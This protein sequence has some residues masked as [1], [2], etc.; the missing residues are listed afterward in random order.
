[1]SDEYIPE[2]DLGIDD[3][4]EFDEQLEDDGDLE[5]IT[6][7]EVDRVVNALEE[8]I[9]SVESENIR[10]CLEEASNSIYYLIYEDDEEEMDEA[11]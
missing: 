10:A 3:E 2:D 5:E 9:G 8:L 4:L 11:A 1:M 6:S 7:D